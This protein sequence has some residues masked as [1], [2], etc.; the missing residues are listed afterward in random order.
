MMDFKLQNILIDL[1]KILVTVH[2]KGVEVASYAAPIPILFKLLYQFWTPCIV[3]IILALWTT[4][5]GDHD[6][7]LL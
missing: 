6:L 4:L 2:M 1:S 7:P 5:Y 3:T